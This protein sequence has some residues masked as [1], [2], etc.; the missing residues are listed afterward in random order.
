MVN[1]FVIRAC[2]PL[3]PKKY[4][5]GSEKTT[6]LFR[7]GRA[8]P[9]YKLFWIFQD[10]GRGSGVFPG[11]VPVSQQKKAGT[12]SCQRSAGFRLYRRIFLLIA[13]L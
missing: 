6:F 2:A 1:H 4:L 11:K 13:G 12:L 10:I 8:A 9:K 7:H 5:A 3:F